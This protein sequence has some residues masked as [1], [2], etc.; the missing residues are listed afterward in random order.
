[1]FVSD[2]MRSVVADVRP[3]GLPPDNV[4]LHMTDFQLEE[5]LSQQIAIINIF[6]HAASST[7]SSLRLQMEALQADCNASA[8]KP[9]VK[10]IPSSGLQVPSASSLPTNAVLQAKQKDFQ[11]R[12]GP[13]FHNRYLCVKSRRPPFRFG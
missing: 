10:A 1:M 3:E 5:L 11:R 2:L 13:A 4:L 9:L 7:V 12:F 8:Q 6:R